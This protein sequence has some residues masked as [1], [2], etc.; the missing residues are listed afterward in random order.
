MANNAL[1]QGAART[2]KKFLDVG[3]EVG[4]GLMLGAAANLMNQTPSR[5]KANEAIQQKVNG[6]MSKMKTDM[7]FTSFT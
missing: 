2:G 7:D 3:T 6:Y 5:T 1:I 4:K